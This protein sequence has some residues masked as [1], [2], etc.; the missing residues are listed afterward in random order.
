MAVAE[1]PVVIALEDGMGIVVRDGKGVDESI[2]ILDFGAQKFIKAIFINAFAGN[3]TAK[4]PQTAAVA[5]NI[6]AG[7][8]LLVQQPG[9]PS[10]C[11]FG[12]MAVV[13]SRIQLK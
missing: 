13:V 8:V 12:S 3:G 2:G 10:C 9:N 6:L 4:A 11:T 1:L 7:K 5:Q